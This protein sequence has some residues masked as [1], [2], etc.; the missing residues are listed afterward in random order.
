[1][2]YSDVTR[3]ELSTVDPCQNQKNRNTEDLTAV[4]ALLK[5]KTEQITRATWSQTCAEIEQT[6][7]PYEIF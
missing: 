1:M 4:T 2:Q 7:H 6:I 5:T 3:K